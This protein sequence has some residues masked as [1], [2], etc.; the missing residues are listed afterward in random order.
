MKK[1][2]ILFLCLFFTIGLIAQEAKGVIF[3]HGTFAEAL[4]KAKKNKKGPNIIFMDCYT[5]WCGPCKQMANVIFPMEHV[6]KYFN[7]NFVNVKIDMEKGEGIDL[8]KKYGIRAYP[9]F[10]ILDSDGNEINRILGSA[11]ADSFIEKVKKALDPST[12]PKAKRA[13]FDANKSTENAIAYLEVLK[14]S[15]MNAEAAAFVVEIFPTLSPR[16]KYSDKMWPFVSQILQN[17]DSEVFGLVM[18]E[19]MTADKIVSKEK[20]DAAICGGLKNYAGTFVTGR[21]ANANNEKV[22][23]KINYLTLLSGKD[24]TASYFVKVAQ[25]YAKNDIDAI[26][27]MLK[28]Q[29]MMKLSE[30]DRNSAEKLITG[31]KGLPKEKVVEYLKAK[32]DYYKKMAEQTTAA[33]ERYSK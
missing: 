27:A 31:V 3:E 1:I 11:D 20:V 30:N 28:V 15:Y 26:A 9:T 21:M 2:S 12:S 24:E 25:L 13:A 8:A 4:A 7:A 5:T 22:L 14:A 29:D 19:K 6:G 10:L 17:P 33:I 23:A 16:E 32:Q 18:E